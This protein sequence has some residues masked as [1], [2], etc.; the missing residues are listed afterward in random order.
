MATEMEEL[1]RLESGLHVIDPEPFAEPEDFEQNSG[2]KKT[3][4]PPAGSTSS[5]GLSQHSAIWYLQRAQKYSSYVFS[6]FVRE[7][8]S[9]FIHASNKYYRRQCT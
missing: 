2:Y 5:L 1:D 3:T 6:A 7:V 4:T 8:D 9:N